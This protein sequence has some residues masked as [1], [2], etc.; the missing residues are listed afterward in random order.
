LASITVQGRQIP[1]DASAHCLEEVSPSLRALEWPQLSFH[2]IIYQG[3]QNKDMLCTAVN[4]FGNINRPQANRTP[5]ALNVS[6]DECVFATNPRDAILIS[7]S[8]SN[9]I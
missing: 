1:T 7:R 8:T 3:T 5:P 6:D 4:P 2:F 9:V